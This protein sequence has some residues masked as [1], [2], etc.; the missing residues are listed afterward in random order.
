MK[1]LCVFSKVNLCF[2]KA[3]V[4][5][6]D[7]QPAADPYNVVC[8][9]MPKDS[10]W[11]D[12]LYQ[13]AFPTRQAPQQ[14]ISDAVQDLLQPGRHRLE[15]VPHCAPSLCTL[16]TLHLVTSFVVTGTTH[17]HTTQCV[18]L[19]SYEV[20]TSKEE[21]KKVSTQV[22]MLDRKIW[23]L[24]RPHRNERKRDKMWLVLLSNIWFLWFLQSMFLLSYLYQWCGFCW[25]SLCRNLW[26]QFVYIAVSLDWKIYI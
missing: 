22:Y 25:P 13:L 5:C 12:Q 18:I 23:K 19:Q 24:F 6:M 11:Y 8:N 10:L 26:P 16:Y 14:P 15:E 1:W 4:F 17:V 20:S 3:Q 2:Q 7:L 9:V 21:R